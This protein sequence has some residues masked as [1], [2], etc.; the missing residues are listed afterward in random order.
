MFTK[1]RVMPWHVAQRQYKLL[2]HA[3]K[4]LKRV[5]EGRVRK[6]EKIDSMY[7]CYFHS[8]PAAGEIFGKE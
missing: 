1:E 5:I 3:I 4:V 6:I 7:E 2:E 8:P